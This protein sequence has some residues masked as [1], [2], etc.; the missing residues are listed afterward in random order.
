MKRTVQIVLAVALLSLSA[1]SDACAKDAAVV[2][3]STLS[4]QE[5]RDQLA[6]VQEMLTD[7]D[8]L[9]RE[10]NMEEIIKSGDATR[11]RIALRIAVASDDK[12]LRALAMR[13]YLASAKEIVF[14]ITMPDTLQKAYDAAKSNLDELNE[15]FNHPNY[16]FMAQLHSWHMTLYI[17]IVDYNMRSNAGNFSETVNNMKEKGTFTVVGET[18]KGQLEYNVSG[19][20]RQCHIVFKPTRELTLAGII[21]CDFGNHMPD[22]FIS[23]P[24]F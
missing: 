7:P 10:A 16:E 21:A 2:D 12:D 19:Y 18:V 5:R 8:P 15:L 24:M 9:M 1:G 23:A 20:P 6:K 4:S 17:R 11:T 3:D 22:L 14:D 13:A